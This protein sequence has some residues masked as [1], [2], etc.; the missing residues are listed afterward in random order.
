MR[1]WLDFIYN[2]LGLVEV[3]RHDNPEARYTNVM[4]AAPG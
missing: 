4:L 3:G 1:E 2:K